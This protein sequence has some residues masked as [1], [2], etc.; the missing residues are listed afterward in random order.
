MPILSNPRHERFAQELAKGKTASE[1][2]VDAGYKEN[3]HNAAALAREQHIA[4]RLQE[5][6]SRVAS[7]VEVTLE[8]LLREAEEVR[9]AAMSAGQ[10]APAVAAIKEKG[11]LSG[12]R[13]EKR[14]NTNKQA[15]DRLTDEE[16]EA[17]AAGRSEDTAASARGPSLAH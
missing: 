11:V 4:T 16:L 7:R 6:Q 15:L 2:Y 12:L 10:F 3:R 5:L 17:I 1:A 14:E 9:V 8:S 13:V